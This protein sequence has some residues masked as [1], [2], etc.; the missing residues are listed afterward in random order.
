[1]NCGVGCLGSPID[2][3]MNARRGSGVTV[4]YSA[5]SRSKGYGCNRASCGFNGG[6]GGGPLLIAAGQDISSGV[7]LE[8]VRPDGITLIDGGARRDMALRTAVSAEKPATTLATAA[9]A[10]S[11]KSAACSAPAGFTGPIVRLN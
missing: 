3:L 9:G 10:A 6:G 1:M 2:R 4:A 11:A 7:S 8:S 5:R